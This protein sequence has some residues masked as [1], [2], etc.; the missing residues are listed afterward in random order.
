[1]MRTF[2]RQLRGLSIALAL[3]ALAGSARA[4]DYFVSPSGKDTNSGKSAAQAWKTLAKVSS[5]DFAPGDRILLESGA[6]FAGPLNLAASDSGTALAPLVITSSSAAPATIDAGTGDGF[7]AWNVSGVEVRNLVVLGSGASTNQGEGVFFYVDLGGGVKLDHVVLED[8]DVHGF[9]GYGVQLG[10]GSASKSGFR[11]VTVRQLDA[12]ANARAGMA[13]WGTFSASSTTWAHANLWVVDCTFRDNLGIASVTNTNTGSGIWV[14][15]VDGATIEYCESFQNGSLCANPNGGPVGIWAFDANDVTIQHCESHHNRTGPNS[16]DGGGFDLDGGVTNS[17]LQYNFSH[18]N[19]GAGFLL[20]QY[21]GARPFGD[22]VVRYNVSQN[23]ARRNGYGAL[24]LWS[25][26]GAAALRD[27]ELYHNTVFLAASTSPGAS[28]VALQ[29]AVTNVRLYNNIFVTT[30]GAKLVRSVAQPGA[31]FQQNDY[32]PSGATFAIQ[33]GGT[34]YASLAAWR[35]ATGQEFFGA[36]VAGT[37]VDPRLVAPG[38]A[39][40]VGDP[41]QLASLTAYQPLAISPLI[42]S[43]LDLPLLYGIDVGASDFAGQPTPHGTR[44]DFGACEWQGP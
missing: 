35:T 28:A 18:D 13:V 10:S 44:Y 2:D 20:A 41:H 4:T 38:T 11:D 15:D 27:C 21:A 8:L 29:T 5:F 14:S 22:N 37:A 43:A 3:G 7:F 36:R 1:M 23:D 24:D 40:T 17:R 19:D 25:G 31:Y 32:F 12:H 34:T 30:G 6:V 39:S 42:N 9:G 26:A 33:W 16:L